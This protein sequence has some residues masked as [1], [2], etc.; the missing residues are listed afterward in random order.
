M[1]Q[2]FDIIAEM[3]RLLQAAH[4]ERLPLRVIGGLA[5][6]VHSPN[7]RQ[8]FPREYPDIDFVVHKHDRRRL[9]AFFS[10]LG[11]QAD[12]NFNLLNGDRRQIFI[13][14]ESGRRIDVFV[15]DFEMCHKLPMRDRL[16]IHPVT[17][18][19]AELFLSKAQIVE[20]NR[21]DAFDLIALLLDNELGFDDDGK[22]NLD[23]IM[24]LCRRDWGLYKTTSINLKR[25]EELLHSEN[26][27]LTEADKGIVLGRIGQIRR[28]L[29]A[30]PTDFLWKARDRLGTRIRWYTEV[31]EVGR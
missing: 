10:R 21:K 15:G 17:V 4:E 30:M 27:S 9:D 29:A 5:V 16:Q 13:H 8:R 18:P 1:E 31:E 26:A 24:R 20:L 6:R 22:I 23:R 2:I 28:A 11:Y 3:D 19:L 12:R 25:I 14:C 7:G